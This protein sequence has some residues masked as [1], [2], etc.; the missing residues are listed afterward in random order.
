MVDENAGLST[1]QLLG[2]N[3]LKQAQNSCRIDVNQMPCVVCA[4]F[5][6]SVNLRAQWLLG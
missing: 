4:Y 5:V 3:I 6:L 1:S 2:S